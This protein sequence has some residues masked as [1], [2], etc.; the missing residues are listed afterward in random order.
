MFLTISLVTFLVVVL[1]ES[2]ES[3]SELLARQHDKTV[4]VGMQSLTH[5]SDSLFVL[6]IPERL[7]RSGSSG[8]YLWREITGCA[9][10]CL[11]L[12]YSSD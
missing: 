1:L 6:R 5:D 12:S 9:T 11:R 4:A 8:W 3:C 10:L 7:G 2:L